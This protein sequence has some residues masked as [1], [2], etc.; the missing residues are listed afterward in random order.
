MPYVATFEA[1]KTRAKIIDPEHASEVE[2]TDIHNV[3]L[4]VDRYPAIVPAKYANC[5]IKSEMVGESECG[6]WVVEFDASTPRKTEMT[7]VDHAAA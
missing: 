5:G 2:N 3:N 6:Q 1:L 4:L 7:S